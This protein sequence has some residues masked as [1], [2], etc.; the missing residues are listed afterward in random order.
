MSLPPKAAP[1]KK[2]TSRYAA[3][4]LP[5]V[6]AIL[7]LIAA[8]MPY[9]GER[10]AEE[11]WTVLDQG[12]RPVP[13][14]AVRLEV[15]EG[16]CM[17]LSNA[18][19]GRIIERAGLVTDQNGQ[20]HTTRESVWRLNPCIFATDMGTCVRHCYI[21]DDPRFRPVSTCEDESSASVQNLT[22]TLARPSFPRWS[23]SMRKSYRDSCRTVPYIAARS[24]DVERYCNCLERRLDGSMAEDRFMRMTDSEVEAM[25]PSL[26][27]PCRFAVP[28]PKERAPK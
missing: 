23:D 7:L 6:S 12:G 20:I 3:S 28:G 4:V 10:R 11:T 9:R 14:L 19:N 17:A 26:D 16:N 22:I 25:L 8:C 2:P 1:G 15:V 21:V 5:G 13:G 27:T 24:Q 18:G